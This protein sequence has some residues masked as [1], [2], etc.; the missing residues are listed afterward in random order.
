VVRVELVWQGDLRFTARSGDIELTLDSHSKAGPSP[1]QTL[2]FAL[3][4]CMAMD[5]ASILQKGRHPFTGLKAALTGTRAESEPRRLT[6]V[7]LHF[8]IEGTVLSDAVERAITQSREKYC[9][10]WHSMRQD[11]G[12][13]VTFEL[14]GGQESGA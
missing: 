8:M 13:D 14:L 12:F 2:A 5:V 11:I 4:G 6:R 9:S 7:G 1:V 10:V 3:A